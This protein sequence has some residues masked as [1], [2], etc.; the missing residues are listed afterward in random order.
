MLN[1]DAYRENGL[2]VIVIGGTR[3]SRGLTLEGLTVSYFVRHAGAHDTLLQ[4]GRWFGFRKGYQDL[5]RVYLTSPIYEDLLDMVEIERSLRD[6]I[7]EYEANNLSPADF[8]VRVLKHNN[9]L[10]PTGSLK[11]REVELRSVNEDRKIF[12]TPNLDLD[13]MNILQN[14]LTAFDELVL[15]L[16]KTSSGIECGFMGK[17]RLWTGISPEIIIEFLKNVNFEKSLQNATGTKN[18]SL[19]HQANYQL[20]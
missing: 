14:N 15:Q 6:D 4:M 9:D 3:L 19:H 16:L 2:R 10:K 12:E 5:M 8:G 20:R 18:H 17:N 13:D 1:Y 11:M 7:V